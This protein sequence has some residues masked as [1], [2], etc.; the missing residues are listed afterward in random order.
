MLR[1]NHEANEK[2]KNRKNRRL[3]GG[4][5]AGKDRLHD[6]CGIGNKSGCKQRKTFFFATWDVISGPKSVHSAEV[7]FTHVCFVHKQEKIYSY[8]HRHSFS[9]HVY[10]HVLFK[11]TDS[12]MGGNV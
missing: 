3:L 9:E 6:S 1:S 2:T 4:R 7:V 5:W 10:M 12:H 11:H 8:H